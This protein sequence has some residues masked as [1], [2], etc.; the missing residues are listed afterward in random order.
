[1]PILKSL[2]PFSVTRLT[3]AESVRLTNVDTDVVWI[4]RVG[5]DEK[6]IARLFVGT[7]NPK[8]NSFDILGIELVDHD[9]FIDAH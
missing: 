4:I 6:V 8:W 3:F 7:V 1:L 5:N 9:D 2:L